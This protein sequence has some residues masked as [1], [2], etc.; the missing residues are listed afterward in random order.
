MHNGIYQDSAG[1][2][3]C[4]DNQ[5]DWKATTPLYLIKKGNFYGHPSSLV[6]DK[7]WPKDKDPLLTYRN[8]LDALQQTSDSPRRPNPPRRNQ[9]LRLRP[10]RDS[11]YLQQSLRRPTP[12]RRQQRHSNHPHHAR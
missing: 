5:G 4:G 6:W 10:H 8:D 1:R 9:P 12:P 11:R 7:D 3:W 2:L